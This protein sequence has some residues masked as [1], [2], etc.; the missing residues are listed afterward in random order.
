MNS[1]RLTSELKSLLKYIK[2]D[3]VTRFPRKELPLE[4]FMLAAYERP[5]CVAHDMLE[6]VMM[7][8]A[9][10]TLLTFYQKHL[11]D[12]REDMVDGNSLYSQDYDRCLT[13]AED[14]YGTPINSGHLLIEIVKYS[15]VIE[16]TF[17][18]VGVNLQQLNDALDTTE[19]NVETEVYPTSQK[20]PKR[21]SKK[22]PIKVKQIHGSPETVGEAERNCVVLNDIADGGGI[23]VAY[24]NDKVIERM[25][26]ILSMMDDN[27]V[28]LTSAPGVGK[29]TTVEH[30]A[31][32]LVSGKVP[33]AYRGRKLLRLDILNLEKKYNGSN[34]S[35]RFKAIVTDISK[36]DNYIIFIDNFDR[37]LDRNMIGGMDPNI[38]LTMLLKDNGIRLICAMNDKCCSEDYFKDK[39]IL[40]QSVHR[41]R[42]E[43]KTEEET[44]E[45][46]KN[47]S[48]RLGKFHAVR[49]SDEAIETAVRLGKKHVPNAVLPK[50]ALDVM[51]EAGAVISMNNG[52]DAEVERLEKRL[53]EI[54]EE[55]E[56]LD[57]YDKYDELTREQISIKSEIERRLKQKVKEDERTDV[58]ADMI[59]EVISKRA[60]VPVTK[61]TDHDIESLR[62]LGPNLL[63]SVIG[64]DEAVNEVCRAVKRKRMGLSDPSKPVV[65]FF[66]GSTGT[67]KT[68]LA[69][70]LAEELFGN[71]KKFTRLDMSEYNDRMSVNKLYGSSAGYVGYE[72][73]GILTEAI[74]KNPNS[75]LLLDE[76]EKACDDV[77]DVF[78]QIFDDG[79]LTD[80]KGYTVDFSNVVII[81][82]SNVGAKEAA[83]HGGGI[84]FV[85]SDGSNKDIFLKSM[86]RK[87]KPEFINRIDKTVFFN[88]LSDENLK[89][90]IGIELEKVRAR[91]QKIGYDIDETFMHG[92]LADMVM[93]DVKDKGEYGA[94]PVIHS[95]Q[96]IVEDR[97]TDYIIDNVSKEGTV[98]GEEVWANKL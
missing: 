56:N 25:F 34:F 43:E 53:A 54:A 96:H 92:A 72:R 9:M 65:L 17:K 21:A 39:P 77:H 61:I 20:P 5:D 69:K 52:D 67:G 85:K 46:A 12:H 35:D 6:K 51:D 82:T 58:T 14:N 50:T 59:R 36:R 28:L 19:T 22:N 60:A 33:S 64:Q 47:R 49:Y 91:I 15:E 26:S 27:N 10:D 62:S 2:D 42:L 30:I 1:K 7:S 29:T 68:Y 66:A 4:Y 55:R 75:I 98:F 41:I 18:T 63:K 70:K 44:I 79:R 23:P 8:E 13:N 93:E 45:I 73:G 57:S 40:V 71:E 84:G 16:K 88:K 74:K 89:T 31:N 81:M 78:L 86:K 37:V 38:L 95:I 76:M 11:N 90:I 83:E 97:L 3:L 32:L 48:E 87:F 94:R 80:N 24:G